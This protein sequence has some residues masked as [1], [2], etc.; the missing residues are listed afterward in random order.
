MKNDVFL[1]YAEEDRALAAQIAA[2]LAARG[3]SVWWDRQIPPGKTWRQTIEDAISGMGCM[4]V[5]WSTHS[6]QSPWV[7]E[8]A[9][10][11]LAL[12]RLVPV[13]IESV[14]PPM[15]FRSIQACDL[16][17]RD[18][19]MTSAAGFQ[20]L[21][22]AIEALVGVAS[23]QVPAG[24]R[25]DRESTATET[26]QAPGEPERGHRMAFILVACAVALAAAI[27]HYALPDPSSN[28]REAVVV[29]A[30]L[31]RSSSPVDAPINAE[32]AAPGT[33]PSATAPSA[34]PPEPRKVVAAATARPATA[35]TRQTQS[36]KEPRSPT[37]S[38]RCAAI[39]DRRDLGDPVSPSEL[40]ECRL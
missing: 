28:T 30:T 34:A 33:L 19:E 22:V 10:E 15:G 13:L 6:I 35:A 26:R 21:L 14:R 12:A 8:E 5:L 36:I 27:V 25:Q 31:P 20:Q 4:V 23:S 32:L 24:I 1:S 11:G 39:R 18:G 29:P 38:I 17:Q 2:A 37:L 40:K 9:E 16:R 7:Q 3:W